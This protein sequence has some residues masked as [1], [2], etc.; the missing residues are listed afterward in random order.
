MKHV[1]LVIVLALALV[2]SACAGQAK[3]APTQAPA[4]TAA[5]YPSS[6]GAYPTAA[7]AGG[8]YP[9]PAQAAPAGSGAYPPA[10]APAAMP[11]PYQPM[12]EDAQ[13]QQGEVFLDSAQI[14]TAESMPPQHMLHLTGN[15]PT[16]CHL[17]RVEVSPPDA[18][19]KIAV[20]VY[21]VVP[22]DQACTQVLAPFD[23]TVQLTGLASG[24]YTVVVNDQ[25][26]GEI[27]VP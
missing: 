13:M 24:T 9:Y 18:Q 8:A 17:L 19:N 3:P 15:M 10:G 4:Q 16:P 2:L 12:P 20:K 23:G 27:T 7:P 1:S 6:Q 25:P 26:A 14:T 22:K 5:P 11:Q 21:S